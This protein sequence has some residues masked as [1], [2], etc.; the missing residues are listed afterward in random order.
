MSHTTASP[1]LG[2]LLQQFFVDYLMQQRR[3]GACTVAAYRDSFQRLFAFAERRLGKRPAALCLDD[4]NANLILEFLKHLEKDRHN[5]IRSR[6]ARF[7]A[8]RSFMHYVGLKEPQ[9]WR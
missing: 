4:L 9:H 6:N 8:I 7:A 1:G 5:S 3:V 2:P